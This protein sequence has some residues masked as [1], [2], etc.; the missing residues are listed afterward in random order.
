MRLGAGAELNVKTMD[1][2]IPLVFNS[3]RSTTLH[4]HVD[5]YLEVLETVLKHQVLPGD[6]GQDGNYRGN[7]VI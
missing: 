7:R 4:M 6:S 5:F 1:T 2:Y 3:I